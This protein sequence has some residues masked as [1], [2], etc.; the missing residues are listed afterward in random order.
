MFSVVPFSGNINLNLYIIMLVE[1]KAVM[2]AVLVFGFGLVSDAAMS[3]AEEVVLQMP[4]LST[5]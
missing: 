4:K 3:Y 5:F 2:D 1:P